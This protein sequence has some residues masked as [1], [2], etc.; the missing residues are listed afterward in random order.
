M[1]HWYNPTDGTLTTHV[2]NKSKPG[3]L[4]EATIKDAR[5]LGL[6][7]SVT[8]VIELLAKPSLIS[9]LQDNAIRSAHELYGG[10]GVGWLNPESLQAVR[11]HADGIRD[12][13]ATA[14]TEIHHAVAQRLKYEAYE[15]P[16]L[17]V[18]EVVE[19]FFDWYNQ[20]ER[21]CLH[22]ERTFVTP[23]FGGTADWVG[24]WDGKYTLADFKTQDAQRWQDFKFYEEVGIQLAGYSAGL[25]SPIGTE[26]D[27]Y[28]SRY[29][30]E[31]KQA[32]FE[33]RLSIYISR[34]KPGLVHAHLW[35]DS[36]HWD[37]TWSKLLSLWQVM[38][39]WRVNNGA[40]EADH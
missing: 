37:E 6:V 39:K 35:E 3:E 29:G 14:G 4:R 17:G 40:D 11:L 1:G 10:G 36:A 19:G 23:E 16:L 34:T 31:V 20:Q 25:Q 15:S 5:L 30:E 27:Y 28:I 9:W 2:P 21:V 22:S 26:A 33:Q 7:P 24:I 12:R 8:G 32:P 38:K 13:A 18:D